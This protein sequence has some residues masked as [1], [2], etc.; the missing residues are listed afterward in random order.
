MEEVLRSLGL[1][2][3]EIALTTGLLLVVI[4]FGVG[5]FAPWLAPHSYREQNLD[6]VEQPPSW[7]YPLGTDELG[8]DQLSRLIWGARTAVIVAPT[9]THQ[10]VL[11]LQAGTTQGGRHTYQQ[12]SHNH[13]SYHG[14]QPEYS[15]D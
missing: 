10:L 8:R 12:G 4:M 3:P 7:T 13:C 5:I 15:S 2:K 6:A 11:V 14:R 9:V 1:F